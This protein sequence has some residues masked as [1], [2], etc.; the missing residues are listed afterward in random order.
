M[1]IRDVEG[2]VIKQT[3]KLE[4]IVYVEF[5][6]WQRE[7]YGNGIL[8]HVNKNMKEPRDTVKGTKS[9]WAKLEYIK[10]FP[11]KFKNKK[12]FKYVQLRIITRK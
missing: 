8:K 2:E 6:T 9:L 5:F 3:R 10:N 1:R 4:N 12:T 11:M 7:V